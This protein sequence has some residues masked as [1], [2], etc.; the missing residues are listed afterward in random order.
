MLFEH[1]KIHPEV[2]GPSEAL[3]AAPLEHRNPI[4]GFLERTQ[5]NTVSIAD[6][7]WQPAEPLSFY[8]VITLILQELPWRNCFRVFFSSIT[9]DKYKCGKAS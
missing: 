5:T 1:T 7:P 6:M 8:N 9:V 3:D 4:P 2:I